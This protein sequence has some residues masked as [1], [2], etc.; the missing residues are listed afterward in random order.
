MSLPERRRPAKPMGRYANRHLKGVP[1]PVPEP[2]VAPE[3][4]AREE[5]SG[6]K[7]VAKKAAE[8]VEK[9]AEKVTGKGH[10]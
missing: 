6:V 7:K 5:D 8:K 4:Q 10:Q 9:V 2:Q 1:A 3:P